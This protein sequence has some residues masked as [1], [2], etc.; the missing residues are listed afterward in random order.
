MFILSSDGVHPNVTKRPLGPAA[1]PWG[2]LVQP[3]SAEGRAAPASESSRALRFHHA[4]RLLACSWI[5]VKW[6]LADATRSGNVARPTRAHFRSR[7]EISL[8]TDNAAAV[9]HSWRM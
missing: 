9:N 2:R 1:V 7:R 3:P 5:H 6:C 4:G 8:A